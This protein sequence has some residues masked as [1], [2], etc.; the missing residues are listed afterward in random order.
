MEAGRR[1]ELEG[2]RPVEE[3][4]RADER[5][6][7]DNPQPQQVGGQDAQHHADEMVGRA[8]AESDRLFAALSAGGKVETAMQDMF[9]GDY[10]GS[11]RDR[12]GVQWM[13][14]CSSKK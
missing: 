1:A 3:E 5:R 10:F 9:W 13:I 12:F 14:N 6:P 2:P 7:D 8:R 11:F 4:R